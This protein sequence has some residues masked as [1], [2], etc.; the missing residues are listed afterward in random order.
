LSFVSLVWGMV[1]AVCAFL[2]IFVAPIH[3][4]FLGDPF[5]RLIISLIQVI[6]AVLTVIVL[7][8]ALSK[9]KKMYM[10]RQLR[11]R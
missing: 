10:Q 3:F 1:L 4:T 2:I 6:I 11:T 5:D 9:L 8:F 7:A